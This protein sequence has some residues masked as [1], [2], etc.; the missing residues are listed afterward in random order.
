MKA[1]KLTLISFLC[2]FLYK[3]ALGLAVGQLYDFQLDA[4]A[5]TTSI[6]Y[7]TSHFLIKWNNQ[8]K[9][10]SIAALSDSARIIWSSIPGK[11]FV[12]ASQG[13]ETITEE[14]GSFIVR[15]FKSNRSQTQSLQSVTQVNNDIKISGILSGTTTSVYYTMLI[16]EKDAK[17]IQLSINVSDTSYD[18]LYLTY[19]SESQEQFFGLGEQPSFFNHKGKRVPVLVNEQGVGRGDAY[20]S[21][22]IVNVVVGAVLGNSKGDEYTTYKAVPHYISSRSRSLYLDNYE[23]AEIDFTNATKVQIELFSSTMNAVVI[24][25]TN[26]LDAIETYTSYCGRMRKLPTWIQNGAV[27][28]MQGGTDK[29]YSV[30]NTLKNAGTPI[31]AFWL[32]D[33]VGQRTTLV[34]KQLWWN[35]ELD[36]QHYH[37]WDKLVDSLHT[38]GIEVMGYINPFIVD[39]MG[40]KSN[41]R[42]N[43]YKE[44]KDNLFLVKDYNG[45]PYMVRNTSFSSAILDLSDTNCVN[46]VKDIIKD[47]LIGR[48]LKGWMADFGEA[49]P[50]DVALKSGISTSTY[51]NKYPEEWVRL[52]REAIE[53]AGY[54][55]SIVF[56]ARSGYT[57]SPRSSTLFW[58]GDQ[59]V[60]WGKNDGLKSAVTSLLSSG[61]S[62]YTLN[63]SD[64]GGYTSVGFLGITL[65]QRSKE[66]LWRWMELSAFTPVFR[67][68]EGL[69]PDINY[70][71]YQDT[72]TAKHFA[73]NANIYKAW[74]F[75]RNHLLEDAATKGI[76]IC[77]HLFL[78][79]PN[80]ANV[81]SLTSEE[82]MVGAELL[83]APITDPNTTSVRVYLPRGNWI[84]L[85]TNE[86]LISA[87]QYFTIQNLSNKPG[88]FYPKGSGVGATLYQ[89]LQNM[90]IY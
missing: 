32:Q 12:G 9:Q 82:F 68:H 79:Y 7:T 63:H 18:R 48:G 8:N 34:G 57:K 15:D 14:A 69:G 74:Q 84:N 37:D 55:D 85:W 58:Q 3:D 75:Y 39:V 90:G 23:Y 5:V 1:P 13:T 36:N 24:A 62:G 49:L 10:L 70:Q 26:P 89:N 44:A 67:T 6:R 11:G 20:A 72:A 86:E 27:I 52:N 64:I 76:P 78:H 80:D 43:E 35:W 41:F 16:S 56:F 40:Q 22:P 19:E 2:L 51:H 17:Q 71:V 53:E 38:Q 4:S 46:W 28:G 21:N 65:L 59:I 88:V 25:A 42:R 60:G 54:G 87:G 77:R 61:I 31:A 47:E 33:W 83:V 73:R 50:Y 81:Y 30:W 66:L 45:N 29:V